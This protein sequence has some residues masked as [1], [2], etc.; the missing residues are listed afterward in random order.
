MHVS[1]YGGVF[2]KAILV[3]PFTVSR[4]V[5]TNVAIICCS[6]PSFAAFSRTYL[7]NP[8]HLASLRARFASHFSGSGSKAKSLPK[9]VLNPSFGPIKTWKDTFLDSLPRLYDDED[10]AQPDCRTDVCQDGVSSV[11]AATL[12]DP[13]G[14]LEEGTMTMEYL[15]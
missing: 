9:P 3:H 11:H 1:G 8:T 2:L 4:I 7:A 6:M 5:E 10:H 14:K 12:A 13:L 15:Q